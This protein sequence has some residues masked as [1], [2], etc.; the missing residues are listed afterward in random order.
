MIWDTLYKEHFIWI[1]IFHKA[2]H[3]INMTFNWDHILLK[4]EI[5]KKGQGIPNNDFLMSGTRPQGRSQEF[6]QD[7]KLFFFPR[8]GASVGTWKLPE[9][10]R[11]HW[12]GGG[13]PSSPPPWLRPRAIFFPFISS[14]LNELNGSISIVVRQKR[15][16]LG[17]WTLNCPQCLLLNKADVS[18]R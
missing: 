13:A 6:V 1:L 12:S 8:G 10:R 3:F 14:R 2:G 5:S 18:D 11:F 9:I 4:Q 17:R 15:L 7:L 16:Y